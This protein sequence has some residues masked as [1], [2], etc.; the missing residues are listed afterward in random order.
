[1]TGRL[2]KPGDKVLILLS[3]PGHSL[4]AKYCGPY[5][6]EK[7]LNEVRRLFGAYA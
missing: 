7:K 3:I 4:Q 5:L 1:M 6:I 2:G